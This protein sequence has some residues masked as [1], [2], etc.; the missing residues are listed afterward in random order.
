M[1]RDLH[2]TLTITRQ[3]A[4]QAAEKIAELYAAYQAGSDAGTVQKEGDGPVT[5]A[6]RAAN[7]I[8]LRE[9][10]EAF[11]SDAILSEE[12][13]ESWITSGEWTWMVDPLDGTEEYIKAN[14]EFMVMIGLCH[15]GVPVLGV[16]IEP[17]TFDECYAVRGGGAWRMAP[18]A[19]QPTPLRVSEARDP[20][21]MT[22]AVSRSHRSPRVESF[23]QQLNMTKEFISGSVGRKIAL[24]TTGRAD[25]YL[26]PS[27]GTK[28]WDTC[29]PQVIH[30]EAGGVFTTALG[31]P[32]KYVRP[33]G[34]VKNDE[35]ILA[36]SPHAFDQLVAASRKA[37]E[38]PLPPR[39]PK[40]K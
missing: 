27:P 40:K 33:D 5:A 19:G 31:E 3:I 24:V 28:L 26:H 20:A 8:I 2:A 4:R 22:L 14:G 34:D 7:T 32:I 29:A 11:P 17:A 39:A 35:G 15:A 21:Q 18:G 25:V 12:N 36:S 6:D 13:P 1:S 10:R 38:I 9:L 37:W 16:V 23:C 30:E